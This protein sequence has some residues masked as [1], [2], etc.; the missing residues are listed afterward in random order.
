MNHGMR[1]AIFNEFVSLKLLSVAETHFA[2]VIVM[3]KRFKIIKGGLQA[4]VISDKW[5]C[6]REDDV[7]KARFVKE[8]VLDDFWRII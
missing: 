7:G 6:Y 4:M 8:K 3:L 2:S 5:S 1:L